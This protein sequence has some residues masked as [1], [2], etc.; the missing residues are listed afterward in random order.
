VGV[1][2]ALALVSLGIGFLISLVSSTEQQATQLT[3][4][5]LLCAVFFSGLVV[6]LDRLTWPV[7]AV[8]FALPS[9]YATRSLHDVM[10]RGVVRNPVDLAVLIVLAVGLYAVAVT[11]LRMQMRPR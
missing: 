7:R 1:V 4:L 5:L 8:A 3:M 11:T 2:V 10:L 6:S 9:T